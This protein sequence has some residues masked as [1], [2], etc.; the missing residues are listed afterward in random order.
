MILSEKLELYLQEDDV[1]ELQAIQQEELSNE[2]LMELEGGQ[3]EIKR[4]QQ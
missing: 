3:R 4:K 1:T 2:D